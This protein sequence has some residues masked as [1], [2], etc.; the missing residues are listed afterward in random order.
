MPTPRSPETSEVPMR[1]LPRGCTLLVAASLGFLAGCPHLK[2]VVFPG[3]SDRPEKTARESVSK[4]SRHSFRLGAYVFSSDVELNRD[5]PLFR[6]LETLRDQVCRELRLPHGESLIQVY[7]FGDRDRYD[8]YIRAKY[9]DLPERRAFF[10]AQPHAVGSGEDLM[11]FTF[12]SDRVRQDLRHELTHALLHSVLKD[13]PLWLDEG[14][15]EYFELPPSWQGLNRIHVRKLLERE[16]NGRASLTQ[17][18]QLSQVRQMDPVKYREAWAWVYLMLH[19]TP[20]AK[21]VLLAYLQQLRTNPNPGPLQPRLAAV[22]SVPEEALDR[23]LTRLD[24]QAPGPDL[25]RTQRTEQ[26]TRLD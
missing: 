1:Q 13:V 15:A 23:L 20:E 12:W 25:G 6:E 18:E 7:V 9:P 5:L 22:L 24:Q 16:G 4:P 11:V 2:S 26:R 3:Q 10:V 21:D 8:R 19:S 17:L 14:L